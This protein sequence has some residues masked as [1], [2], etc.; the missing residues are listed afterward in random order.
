V[1][2]MLGDG[3]AE[4]SGNLIRPERPERKKPNR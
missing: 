1:V 2:S 4:R 3:I